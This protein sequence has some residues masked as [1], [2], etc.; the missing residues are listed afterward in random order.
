MKKRFL[1]LF[2]FSF[3][4]WYNDSGKIINKVKQYSAFLVFI[5]FS[6]CSLQA[7]TDSVQH[8]KE[9]EVDAPRSILFKPGNKTVELDSAFLAQF[10]GNTLSEALTY[11]GTIALKQY[12]AGALSSPSFR[13]A[14]AA[15]TPVIWNGF[16]ITSPMY[17]Q[18]DLSLFPV[19]SADKISV[20]F[21]PGASQWGSGAVSGAVLLDNKANFNSGFNAGITSSIASFSSYNNL[22]NVGWSGKNVSIS[23]KAYY[24]TAE[25]NFPYHNIAM[26]GK[27][28]ME[29]QNNRFVVSG[30]LFNLSARLKKNNFLDL[31]F[32]YQ[33]TYREIPTM[34]LQTKSSAYQED[35]S[36]KSSLE[37]KHVFEHA[38]IKART[39][40]FYDVLNYLDTLSSL[41]SV[42]NSLVSISEID[43]AY[44][45]KRALITA[46]INSTYTVAN[47]DG[48]EKQFSQ[49]R[50]SLF[51]ML[52]LHSYNQRFQTQFSVR[53]E[54][55]DEKVVYPGLTINDKKY[56]Y[57]WLPTASLGFDIRIFKWLS[58]KANVSTVYR[59]PTLN[60]LYWFPGGNPNLKPEEG[61]SEELT[62]ASAFNIRKLKLSYDVTVFNRNINNWI[63][64]LPGYYY[65]SPEN[66]M[67]V[68]SRGFEHVFGINYVKNKFSL[69]TSFNYTFTLSTN[70]KEK[71]EG[72]AS[73]HKQLIYAPIHQGALK[74]MLGYSKWFVSYMHSYT[75]YRYTLT[76]NT[77]FLPEY[78]IARVTAGRNFVYRKM[79]FSVSAYCNNL[80][81]EEYQSVL[82]RAMPGRS[83]GLNLKINFNQHNN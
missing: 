68:W 76:D 34:M 79:T 43:Y 19:G 81:N 49:W 18:A 65:W 33:D 83:Y 39:G 6:F 32:W 72:D 13:G 27:P 9:I 14:S 73:L 55:I 62:L 60:D 57:E 63:I 58:T 30:E 59:V 40:F 80:M 15:Q 47:S 16:N 64:W 51:V 23:A 74:I 44:T 8:L 28:L 20:Q 70:E 41:N 36:L 69:K 2:S 61:L 50:K 7:Q 22:V 67:K 3:S 24:N 77:E 45:R 46:G 42:S 53:K 29:Q 1:F 5:L 31:N 21:G 12:G 66:I 25:N 54:F 26:E 82:W 52:N 71:V 38:V 75:G 4:H 11:D 10:A 35:K 37:W 56:N 17:G 48:Y 78:D